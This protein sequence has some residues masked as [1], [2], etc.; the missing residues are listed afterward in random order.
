DEQ[1]EGRDDRERP[2]ESPQKG[3]FHAC[4]DSIRAG[5]LL[6]PR[7]RSRGTVSRT[8]ACPELELRILVV[9]VLLGL[10][11]PAAAW[12]AAAGPGTV[13]AGGV[14][15][16]VSDVALGARGLAAAAPAARFDLVAVHW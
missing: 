13:E 15:M 16:T 2:E 6:L 9:T 11:L 8:S 14:T 5:H 3:T 7:K 4:K 12:A 1:E 10:A